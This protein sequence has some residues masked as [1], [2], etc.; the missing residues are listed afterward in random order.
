MTKLFLVIKLFTFPPYDL[1]EHYKGKSIQYTTI[2]FERSLLS[3]TRLL[4]W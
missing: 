4:T 2:L 1:H 3:S